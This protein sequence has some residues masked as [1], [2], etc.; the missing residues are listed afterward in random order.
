MDETYKKLLLKKQRLDRYRPFPSE[1]V[2]NLEEWF[3]VEL[4]YTSN[5]IEGNT[6]TRQETALIVE[7]GITVQGK[8]LQEHLEAV[9]HAKAYDY[10]K[11]LTGKNKQELTFDNVL[12]I[13]RIILQKIDDINA[14]RLRTV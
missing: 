7:K 8:S 1:L 6:L 14:G 5:A 12:E 10:I 2:T 9:N 13:H 4:T 3:R 11:T